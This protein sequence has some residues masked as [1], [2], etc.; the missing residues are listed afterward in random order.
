MPSNNTGSAAAS[1][2]ARFHGRLAH[3]HSVAS[4][5]EPKW[6]LPWALDNGVYGAFTSGAPWS[7]EPMFRYLDTYADR[8]PIWTVVPDWV[9]DRD[10]T[11]RRWGV[12]APRLRAY[13]TPLAMAVQDGM[14][15]SDVPAEASVVFVGGST[16]WK[17]GT[18][19]M[20]TAMFA[21]VHVGR[22]N[23][24]RLLAA[25]EASGAESCD[26]TGWFRHP[27]RTAELEQYLIDTTP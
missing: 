11:L 22:V 10:E 18:L 19:H 3:L 4:P 21:R 26:G 16:S 27:K 12:Y 1:L 15:P 13:G 20:W 7:D 2:F 17:W 14:M 8:D 5:R 25:A 24:K 6:G 9:G 23:S